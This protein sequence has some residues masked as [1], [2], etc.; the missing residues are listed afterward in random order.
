RL[1][2]NISGSLF[3]ER[4]NKRAPYNLAAFVKN[5]QEYLESI[6]TLKPA[7]VELENISAPPADATRLGNDEFVLQGA[8]T[9]LQYAEAGQQITINAR[10]RKVYDREPQLELQDPQGKVLQTYKI[11]VNYTVFPIQFTAMQTGFYR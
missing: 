4:N 3:I 8:F 11:P 5:R 9:F 2:D 7:T 6:R 1:A 10:V